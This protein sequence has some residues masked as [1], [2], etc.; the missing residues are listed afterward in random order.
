MFKGSIKVNLNLNTQNITRF[1][2]GVLRYSFGKL[3]QLFTSALVDE[4]FNVIFVK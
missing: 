4:H 3:Q 1:C 2:L